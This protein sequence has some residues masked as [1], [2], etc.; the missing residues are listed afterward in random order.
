MYPDFDERFSRESERQAMSY[1]EDLDMTTTS[2]FPEEEDRYQ[3]GHEKSRPNRD[4]LDDAARRFMEEAGLVPTPDAIAQ[5]TEAF[6]PAL[7]IV[8]ER[9]HDPDGGSWREKGWRGLVHDI[10]DNAGRL[11]YRSWLHSRFDRNSAVDMINFCAFYLRMENKGAPWG[12]W[13][14]PGPQEN[15]P[16][17]REGGI[18]GVE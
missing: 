3:G 5:L 7:K 8:C 12:E 9:D 10:L 1:G 13:G 2:K 4:I 16:A 17:Q 6:L 15:K 11:R 18:F 14:E